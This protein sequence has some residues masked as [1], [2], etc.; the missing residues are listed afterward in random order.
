MNGLRGVGVLVTRPEHQA[1]PLCRL[2]ESYGAVAF[3][4][5][6]IDIRPAGDSA[7]SAQRAAAAGPFDVIVFTSANAVRHGMP[8]LG[9]NHTIPLAAIGSATARALHEAGYSVTT[10]VHGVDSESLLRHPALARPR[11]LRVL[12]VKG[13]GGREWLQSQLAQ[14]GA[15]V[16]IAEVY[17]RERAEHGAVELAVVTARCAAGEIQ[18]VTATSGD[19]AGHLLDMATPTLRR[20]FERLRWLVPSA[21]VAAV[22]RERGV[23]APIVLADTA[24]DQDLVAALLRWRSSVSG[25]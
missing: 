5:P 13:V 24:E 6:A 16:T 4:L 2:L 9:G 10:P 20:Q 25:A 19:I 14:R 8:L 21:R 22:L 23:T 15:V 1:M 7:E 12:I 3:P 17:R 18:V 11:D